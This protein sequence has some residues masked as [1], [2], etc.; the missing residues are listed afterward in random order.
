M[1]LA[2]HRDVIDI[3]TRRL[4]GGLADGFLDRLPGRLDDLLNSLWIDRIILFVG[5]RAWSRCRRHEL[6]RSIVLLVKLD[7]HRLFGVTGQ[8]QQHFDRRTT[9]VTLDQPRRCPER[10]L[11]GHL[12]DLG[13]RRLA[14]IGVRPLLRAAL[15][16]GARQDQVE[17]GLNAK[18]LPASPRL[19]VMPPGGMC[20]YTVRLSSAAEID[21]EL[22]GWVKAAYAAAG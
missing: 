8:S 2:N 18:D 19:K 15:P 9:S 14:A 1:T 20:Q 21:A 22:L 10:L 5:T 6:H 17:L 11:I 16:E 7:H 13:T 12:H 3:V 4:G